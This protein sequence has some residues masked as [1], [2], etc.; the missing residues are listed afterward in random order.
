MQTY[1]YRHKYAYIYMYLY[2]YIPNTSDVTGWRRLKGSRVFIGHFPRKWPIYSSSFV[3]NDLQL[4]GSHESSPPC[5]CSTYKDI[6]I[7]IYIPRYI[8]I[9]IYVCIYID[10]YVHICI[11]M[12]I[13]TYIYVLTRIY[14]I[15][16]HVYTYINT[17]PTQSLLPAVVVP[18]KEFVL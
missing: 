7:Y 3:E 5:T 18:K 12:C 17:Y 14:N 10:I 2:I 6:Y 4:R 11:L 8:Y 16:I 9:C 15:C 1:I 13:Y